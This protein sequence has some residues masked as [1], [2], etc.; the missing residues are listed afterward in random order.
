MHQIK[1]PIGVDAKGRIKTISQRETILNWQSENALAQNKVLRRIAN[2]VDSVSTS[3]NQM[4]NTFS[5]KVSSLEALICE[6]RTK[7]NALHYVL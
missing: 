7:I 3:M 4:A 5:N 1:N 2:K 6:L